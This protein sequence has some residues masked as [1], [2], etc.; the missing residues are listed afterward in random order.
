M[1]TN[2]P[3]RHV[4]EPLIRA[5]N[6][7]DAQ[8]ALHLFAHDAVIDDPSTRERFEG[9]AGV[10]D[11]MDRFFVGSRTA[12]KLLSLEELKAAGIRARVDFT[13][14]FRPEIGR[15]NVPPAPTASSHAS[16]LIPSNPW[17]LKTL[18]QHYDETDDLCAADY[19][20]EAGRD[21]VPPQPH[22]LLRLGSSAHDRPQQSALLP[23]PGSRRRRKRHKERRQEWSAAWNR[24]TA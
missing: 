22:H 23:R 5:T 13:G 20:G 3:Y 8:A 12:T 1:T 17:I 16:M 18:E 10:R 19:T 9:H 15:L 6:S 24:A 14:D 11:Y 7:F 4:V 21:A 2:Q